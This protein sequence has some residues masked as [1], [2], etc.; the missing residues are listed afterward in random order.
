MIL[1]YMTKYKDLLSPAFAA[2]A[3]PTRRAVLAQL[4]L[5]PASV[6]ALARPFEV[7]LPTFLQHVRVLEEGGLIE[8]AKA[9]RVR[10]CRLVPAGMRA[11][12]DWLGAQRRL[13]E[14]RTDQLEAFLDSGGDLAAPTRE[15]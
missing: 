6:T 8:T 12:E 1:S 15:V 10:T 5:G 9:G 7:A 13:W 3:D 14:Q 11:V 4:A 2:L